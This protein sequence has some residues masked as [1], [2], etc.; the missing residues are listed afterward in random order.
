MARVVDASWAKSATR[1]V[2][3]LWWFDAYGQGGAD[4]LNCAAA[5]DRCWPKAVIRVFPPALANT[6]R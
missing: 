3:M 6:C 2:L 5:N 1:D 4:Q